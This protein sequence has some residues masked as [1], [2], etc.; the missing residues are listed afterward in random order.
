MEGLHGEG[1]WAGA[2]G[3]AG[4]NFSRPRVGLV[5]GSSM[6]GASPS[7]S[8]E[9]GR[10]LAPAVAH[11][12]ARRPPLCNS[13]S[14][15]FQQGF[16]VS[17]GFFCRPAPASG[18]LISWPFWKIAEDASALPCQSPTSP[19]PSVPP[20]FSERL[21]RKSR[22]LER[23]DKG[24]DADLDFEISL[25]ESVCLENALNPSALRP[26]KASEGWERGKGFQMHSYIQGGFYPN[27]GGWAA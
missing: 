13:C 18:L 3:Q 26:W 24:S 17:N 9:G 6:Q 22:P 10:K 16:G 8:H 4:A 1:R 5:R 11:A 7:W 20:K 25:S 27:G 19:P 14:P 2:R 23:A 21:L 12:R 15:V